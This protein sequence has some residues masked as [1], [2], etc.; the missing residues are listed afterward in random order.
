MMAIM[1]DA[2]SVQTQYADDH[3]LSIRINLHAKHS[4]NKQGFGSWL[5]EQ[6][7][8]PQNSRILELGCGGGS[9]WDEHIQHLPKGCTLLLSDF[10]EGMVDCARAKCAQFEHLSFAQIDIQDIPFADES[11]DVMIANHM[12]Y[13]V[14]DLSKAL[15]E[16]SR[17]L[18]TGG[19]FYASTNG[20]GGMWAY[21]YHS[22]KL[23]D[24]NPE[25]FA[26]TFS[27]HLQNGEELLTPYFST[28]CRRDYQDS[29]AITQT[30]D[31][32]DWIQSTISVAS[33][34][35]KQYEQL[36]DYFENIRKVEGVIRIPKE[37]GLFISVK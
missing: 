31:L 17:V 21:L 35:D 37:A 29:L 27:F 8:L 16:V 1:N 25:T 2:Q 9:Q 4:T 18:K 32:I 28:V 20:N 12:L 6:Y 34:S 3:N 19:T 15:S 36:Y 22:L 26:K 5:F 10:S 30:Q 13:H 24:P 23:I 14:P 7:E 11:F 33:Y